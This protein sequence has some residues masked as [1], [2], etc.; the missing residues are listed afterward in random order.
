MEE[1]I[2]YNIELNEQLRTQI[3]KLRAQTKQLRTDVE[4]LECLLDKTQSK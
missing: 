1:F 4:I 3:E 2:K